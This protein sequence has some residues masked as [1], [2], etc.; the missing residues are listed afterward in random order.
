[1]DNVSVR[2]GTFT[3]HLVVASYY[4]V[5]VV[6][7]PFDRLNLCLILFL[8]VPVAAHFK[9]TQDMWVMCDRAS[10]RKKKKSSTKKQHHK[11]TRVLS[12][13]TNLLLSHSGQPNH[14]Y[15]S[16]S[17]VHCIFTRWVIVGSPPSPPS[18]FKTFEFAFNS[19]TLATRI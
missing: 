8:L 9:L 5:C 18:L 10:G 19:A 1:M 11:H 7:C 14:H 3:Q 15:L 13:Y 4:S 2:K 16:S 6:L 17:S 12:S